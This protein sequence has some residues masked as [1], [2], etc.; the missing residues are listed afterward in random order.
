ML[1]HATTVWNTHARITKETAI[2]H[3]VDLSTSLQPPVQMK[4]ALIT[5]HVPS[6][7]SSPSNTAADTADELAIRALILGIV[8]RTA[9]DFA[10]SRALLTDALARHP[11]V[12]ISTW[13]GGVAQFE[14][15]VLDLKEQETRLTSGTDEWAA[16][17]KGALEKLDKALALATQHVDLS[18]RLD[19]RI[20]MLKDEIAAKREMLGITA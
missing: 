7:A 1:T 8:H 14:L 11:S 18:S 10:G 17:L 2:A 12:R 3:I 20:A 15:A 19:S 6:S 5:E 4:T 16:V 13:V 9:G